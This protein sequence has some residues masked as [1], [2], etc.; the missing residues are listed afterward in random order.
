MKNFLIDYATVAIVASL[1]AVAGAGVNLV[2]PERFKSNAAWLI[3]GLLGIAAGI[4]IVI[5]HGL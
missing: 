5:S 3:G 2:I 1:G 4:A